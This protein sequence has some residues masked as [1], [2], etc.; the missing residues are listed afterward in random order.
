MWI[1]LD[2]AVM[3][4]PYTAEFVTLLMAGMNTVRRAANNDM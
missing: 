2:I 1:P 3:S 4:T